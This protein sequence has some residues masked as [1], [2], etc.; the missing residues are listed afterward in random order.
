MHCG[1]ARLG[2]RGSLGLYDASISDS[3]Y[4][5][6]PSKR[7][8]SEGC[9]IIPVWPTKRDDIERNAMSF[10]PSS[11]FGRTVPLE[12]IEAVDDNDGNAM[13]FTCGF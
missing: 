11:I 4:H 10:S 12:P 6:F 13:I 1:S 5:R 9:I 8:C 7:G 3:S 2:L